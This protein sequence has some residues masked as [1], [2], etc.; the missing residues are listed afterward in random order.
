MPTR[1]DVLML[2]ACLS[3]GAL[4][5]ALAQGPPIH[6]DTPIM[7]GLAGR[8]VRSF[9]KVVHRGKLFEGGDAIDN[10]DDREVTIV[11]FPVV[12]PYNLFSERL[13]V[14]FIMKAVANRPQDLADIAALVDAYPELDRKKVRSWV[15]EF[16]SILEMPEIFDQVDSLL[17][18]P[19]ET[20]RARKK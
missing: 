15:R 9:G 4:D 5:E 20:L 10:P 17:K 6:T 2:V 3:A 12:V 8:G 18:R 13:Q 19:Q 11:Q 7:L 14:S 1:V 16:S